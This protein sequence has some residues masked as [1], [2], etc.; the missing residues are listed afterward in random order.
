MSYLT[1]LIL[2]SIVFLIS[3]ILCCP[4]KY[5]VLFSYMLLFVFFFVSLSLYAVHPNILLYLYI[6]SCQVIYNNLDMLIC[7][8]NICI[9]MFSMWFSKCFYCFVFWNEIA[10]ATCCRSLTCSEVEFLLHVEDF[11]LFLRWRPIDVFSSGESRYFHKGDS[12]TASKSMIP[13][14]INQN[15]PMKGGG[16]GPPLENPLNPPV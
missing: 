1:C 4:P 6:I 13:H 9:M 10:D 16:Q 5:F 14:I 11:T 15:V 3:Q 7:C 2:T 8:L 12:L